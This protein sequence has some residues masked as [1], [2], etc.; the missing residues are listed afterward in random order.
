MAIK[1]TIISSK[2]GTGKTTLIANIGG[3][4]ADLGQRVLLVD[5]DPQPTLSSYYPLRERGEHA[6]S[7][8]ITASVGAKAVSRTEI[9]NLDVV[10][11]DDPEGQLRD[12][13]MHDPIGR[14]RLKQALAKLDD[15][16]DFILIDTQGAVGAL[17]ETAAV[18]A[19]LLI[20]PIPPEILSAREFLRGTLTMLDR[21]RPMVH[22]GAP[23]APLRGVIYRQTRTTDARRIAQELRSE[24]FAPSKGQVSIMETV[25]PMAA[26]YP[27]AATHQM[28]VHRWDARR[29]TGATT[30]ADTMMALV[31]EMLP[32]LAGTQLPARF[33]SVRT[34]S[35]Q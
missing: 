33:E 22:F 14:L 23:V 25:V 15:A 8:L 10:V 16:Y 35:D 2:G 13:I 5:A 3:L 20:S 30:A 34:G 1:I 32:H 4:L 12:W 24:F 31:S 19:D 9:D 7:G 11:S 28:P 27:E 18:A 17:A 21:L 29:R 6:L 26:A